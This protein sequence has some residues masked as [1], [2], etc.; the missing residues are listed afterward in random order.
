MREAAGTTARSRDR[1]QPPGLAGR[2]F[3]FL[4]GSSSGTPV[5]TRFRSVRGSLGSETRAEKEKQ[6][7]AAEAA[8]GGEVPATHGVDGRFGAADFLHD[9]L[10]GGRLFGLFLIV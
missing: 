5:A 1:S 4:P 8:S 6:G 9:L 2:L 10:E 7:P 3:L